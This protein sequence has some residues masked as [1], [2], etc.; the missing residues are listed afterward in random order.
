MSSAT[1]DFFSLL[2]LGECRWGRGPVHSGK[3]LLERLI[4]EPCSPPAASVASALPVGLDQRSRAPAAPRS[5]PV[6]LCHAW[7]VGPAWHTGAP[8][9][10]ALVEGLQGDSKWLTL[11]P[12]ES[13]FQSRC[14]KKL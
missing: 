7:V 4:V 8:R 1:F 6:P 13:R 5:L 2:L 9:R 3:L 14:G 10:G 11:Q 12:L